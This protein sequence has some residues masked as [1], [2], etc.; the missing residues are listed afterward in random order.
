MPSGY[1]NLSDDEIR[2]RY[3]QSI[4]VPSNFTRLPFAVGMVGVVG[5]GKSTVAA[6][7]ADKLD[8]YVASNDAIRRFLN[9]LGFEGASPRQELLQYIAESSTRYLMS[10]GISHIMDLDLMKFYS[11]ARQ[12]VESNG[13][14]FYLVNVT[15][16][17]KVILE[18]LSARTQKGAA[19]DIANLS[20]SG[21]EEYYVRKRVHEETK[22]PA[23]FDF[24]FDTSKA[25]EPQVSE[26]AEILRQKGAVA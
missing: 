6:A 11:L 18:R 5:S 26:F 15:C 13:G 1:T 12:N 9:G 21:V 24:T 3:F 10:H 20:R 7:L 4:K 19:H 23:R 22:M 14:R 16:P 2:E 25:L 17:E 8:L